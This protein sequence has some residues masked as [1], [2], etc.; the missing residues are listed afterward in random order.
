MLQSSS[1]SLNIECCSL[2]AARVLAICL[3]H[4][5]MLIDQVVWPGIFCQGIDMDFCNTTT[6]DM[7]WP[8]YTS[9]R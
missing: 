5:Q 1:E 8:T 6:Y 3:L 2:A 4:H 7:Y 9:T